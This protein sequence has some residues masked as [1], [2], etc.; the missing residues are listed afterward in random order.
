M[1]FSAKQ[2]L[3]FLADVAVVTGI[4][5]GRESSMYGPLRDMIA[6]ALGYE[7]R[8][9]DIDRAGARGRPDLTVFA[10]G[11]DAS[12][13]VP[14]IV[15]E[16]KDE[17]GIA[18]HKSR[19]AELFTEKPKYV[20]ADTAWFVMLDHTILSPRP[21]TYGPPGAHQVPRANDAVARE[22]RS[23]QVLSAPYGP[24]LSPWQQVGVARRP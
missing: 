12:S 4:A 1:A 11:G 13:T 8:S 23:C 22:S 20:P 16:A 18:A 5:R 14:W 7:R 6:S 3:D 10:P 21:A 9:I 2:R 15:L 24:P 17:S 19:R